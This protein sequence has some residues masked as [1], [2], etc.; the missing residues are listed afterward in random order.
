MSVEQDRMKAF[1]EADFLP[2]RDR[3]A[4]PPTDDRIA[5]ALEFIA[6]RTGKIDKSLEK[7]IEQM[8]LIASRS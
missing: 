5:T 8:H 3:T 1:L 7:I 6:Y 2:R 4:M